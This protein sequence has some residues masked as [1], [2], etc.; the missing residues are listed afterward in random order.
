MLKTTEAIICFMLFSNTEAMI[1]FI[2]FSYQFLIV[3]MAAILYSRPI[4]IKLF[5][6]SKLIKKCYFQ[7]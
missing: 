2:L 6:H 3:P 1:C 7:A 4:L 5:R